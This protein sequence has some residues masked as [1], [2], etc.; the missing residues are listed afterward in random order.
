[1][2]FRIAAFADL[3][4]N[5]AV[6]HWMSDKLGVNAIATRVAREQID[7][8]LVTTFAPPPPF[9]LPGHQLLQFTYCDAPA[10]V[11]DG[12]YGRWPSAVVM[13]PG[14]GVGGRV[15]GPGFSSGMP[16]EARRIPGF[17]AVLPPRMG[18][19]DRPTPS[20]DTKL[21]LDLDVDA[22]NALLFELWRTGWLD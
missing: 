10:D 8:V 18:T 21:A 19:G 7:D 2:K 1:L 13:G 16:S 9:E 12:R 6:L 20:A 4:F 11:A 15:G 22:L 3:D 14:A 5:N 17:G